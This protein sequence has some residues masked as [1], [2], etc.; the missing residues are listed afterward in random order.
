MKHIVRT[1]IKKSNQRL[2]QSNSLTEAY[3]KLMISMYLNE[4]T[5]FTPAVISVN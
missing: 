2:N 3:F 5:V 1:S 4:V